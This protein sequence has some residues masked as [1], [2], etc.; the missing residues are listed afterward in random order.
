MCQLLAQGMNRANIGK[1]KF[2]LDF[3]ES[4]I[5]AEGE[6]IRVTMIGSFPVFYYVTVLLN[7][8]TALVLN[9]I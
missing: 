1:F 9:L 6:R 8:G 4:F 2:L 5:I 3:I 7:T